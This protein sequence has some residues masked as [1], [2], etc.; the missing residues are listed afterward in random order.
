MTITKGSG[1]VFADLGFS[2]A[3]SGTSICGKISR[4]SSDTLVNMSG[5]EADFRIKPSGR[6]FSIVE[7][8]RGD[9]PRP[10]LGVGFLQPESISAWWSR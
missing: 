4:F 7:P 3:E 10:Q 5:L 6:W 1:D 9:Q 2:P 8:A